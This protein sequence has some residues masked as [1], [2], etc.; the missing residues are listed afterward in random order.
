MTYR[1][2]SQSATEIRNSLASVMR[3]CAAHQEP[4][5]LDPGIGAWIGH[6][7]W[8]KSSLAAGTLQVAQL[9]EHEAEGL[10]LIDEVNREVRQRLR[11]CPHC[12]SVTE[13]LLACTTCG[14]PLQSSAVQRRG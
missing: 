12:G 1:P 3:A 6:L 11:R 7:F 4:P 2:V 9:L 13:S 5:P 10:R 14:R 8:L